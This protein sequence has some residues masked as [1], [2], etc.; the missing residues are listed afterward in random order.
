[1]K[2][3]NNYA[4]LVKEKHALNKTIAPVE[5]DLTDASQAYAIGQNFIYDGVLYKAKTAIAQHDALVLNTNYEAADD[6]VSQIAAKQ[7]PITV[8]NVPT[9]NSNNPVKSGGVYS[10]EANIYEVMGRNGAKNLVPY[11]YYN[12]DS[13]ETNGIAFTVNSD[14]SVTAS[15][16]ASADAYFRCTY[17]TGNKHIA[18]SADTDYILNGTGNAA[19]AVILRNSGGSN[20]ASGRATDATYSCTTAGDYDVILLVDNGTDLTT[21]LTIYPMLRYASDSDDTYQPY[22]K[23]NAELT[24]ENQT[25]SQNIGDI[26]QL[27]TTDKSS[28]VSAIN[29]V[30][31]ALGNKASTS[32]V[33]DLSTA[34]NNK[35]KVTIV[36]VNTSGWTTDTTSQSGTTLYK[37]SI[38]L[39]HVYVDSPS[40]D[41]GASGGI[42]LPTAAQQ[43]AYDLLEYVTVDGTTL[44][45]YASATPTD[46]FYIAVEGVD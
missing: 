46:T 14:G 13:W 36:T 34:V 32:S 30:N 26:T 25:L 35:H 40:V 24:A 2:T 16:T 28:T 37:K 41:I 23:T 4:S 7:D 18:L 42:G 33:T 12:G 38:S 20:V 10:A 44:Y 43:A 15:G 45:L 27:G 39:S 19:V 9:E 21:P 1:M 3:I 22:A 29:E 8:D 6:I 31:T 5:T 17:T 11:P